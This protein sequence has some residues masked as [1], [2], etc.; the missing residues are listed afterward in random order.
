MSSHQPDQR[1]RELERDALGNAERG[2]F[3]IDKFCEG[4]DDEVCQAAVGAVGLQG[5]GGSLNE[6][7]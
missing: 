6:S 5:G 4:G 2:V 7:G 1:W 3:V